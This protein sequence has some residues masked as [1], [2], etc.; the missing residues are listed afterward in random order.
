MKKGGKVLEHNVMHGLSVAF[1][2]SLVNLVHQTVS[3]L[4]CKSFKLRFKYNTLPWSQCH[5][6]HF[7]VSGK[8]E[9]KK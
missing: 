4:N 8:E 9:R 6:S 1:R 5:S 3:P 2:N 7:I